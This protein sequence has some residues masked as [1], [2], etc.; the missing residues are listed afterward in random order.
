VLGDYVFAGA[1]AVMLVG[2]VAFQVRKVADQEAHG[3]RDAF[4][5]CTKYALSQRFGKLPVDLDGLH[6]E[7][8]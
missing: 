7:M 5:V 8:D 2:H 4:Y 1:Y 3:F 6:G